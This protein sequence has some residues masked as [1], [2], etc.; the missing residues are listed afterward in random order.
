MID[1]IRLACRFF[2]ATALLASFAAAA[3]DHQAASWATHE[4]D[5]QYMGFT[6][7]YSCSGLQGTVKQILL[8]LGA[9]EEPGMVRFGACSGSG[10]RPGR[11]AGVHIKVATLQLDTGATSPVDAVWKTV[12]IGGRDLDAD[13]E[14]IEQAGKEIL[15][16]FATRN[17]QPLNVS[18]FPNQPTTVPA[19]L[20]LEVLVPAATAK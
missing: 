19:R 1:R 5:F 11:I 13:C 20:T 18:C 2:T 17:V 16:L 9:K 14:L 7:R 15:P 10:D 6:S 8:Q 4:L 3:Q 12:T